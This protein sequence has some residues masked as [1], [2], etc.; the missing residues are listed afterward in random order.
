MKDRIKIY[1]TEIWNINLENKS[2]LKYYKQ[3]KTKIGYEMCYR[4]NLNSTYLARARMNSLKL[5]EAKGRGNPNYDRTCKL[6]REDKENIVHF[7]IDCKKLDNDRNYEI[8]DSSIADSE[9]RMIK[10]L[11]KTGRYQETGFMIKK[12]WQKRRMLLEENERKEKSGENKKQ[13][14]DPVIYWN[15]DPGPMG[16]GHDFQGERSLGK[17]IRSIG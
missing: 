3:G 4:N 10:L 12:M 17:N 15:S 16:R 14:P 13:V 7:L 8:V 2:T 11:F 6:C 9:E 5:E 1:D